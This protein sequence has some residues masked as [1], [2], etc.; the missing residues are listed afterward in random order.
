MFDGIPIWLK[1]DLYLEFN[2]VTANEY[3][4]KIMLYA[5]VCTWYAL[6]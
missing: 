3:K 4:I 2:K 1:S 6:L 5:I